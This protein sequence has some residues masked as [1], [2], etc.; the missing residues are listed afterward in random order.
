MILRVEDEIMKS[1]HSINT[2][3]VKMEF[4]C[5]DAE[6]EEYIRR[7]LNKFRVIEQSLDLNFTT[8]IT[9]LGIVE[10]VKGNLSCGWSE[11]ETLGKLRRVDGSLYIYKSKI[12]SLGK[13]EKCKSITISDT[14][15]T[16][17]GRI[18]TVG[19]DVSLIETELAHLGNL[20]GVAGNLTLMR[21]PKLKT[22]SKLQYVAGNMS[23]SGSGGDSMEEVEE[24]GGNLDLRDSKIFKFSKLKAIGGFMIAKKSQTNINLDETDLEVINLNML[25]N[26]FKHFP[27]NMIVMKVPKIDQL[28]NFKLIIE[29]DTMGKGESTK[30]I[31]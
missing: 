30:D 31:I 23:V 27:K 14:P 7:H 22:L 8:T 13:L 18:E 19:G 28:R 25:C 17:I 15:I 16:N 20:K 4:G 6:A 12:T 26:T 9:D 21:N 2:L 10:E 1:L 5:T 3:Y 11:V 24:V 29:D